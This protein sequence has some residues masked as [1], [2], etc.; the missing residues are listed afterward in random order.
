M[1]LLESEGDGEKRFEAVGKGWR[2]SKGYRQLDF[3]C[4]LLNHN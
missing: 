2:E 3:I 4:V 1:R